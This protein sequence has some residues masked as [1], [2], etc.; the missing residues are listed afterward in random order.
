MPPWVRHHAIRDRRHER[1]FVLDLAAA[2]YFELGQESGRGNFI[3]VDFG[4]SAVTIYEGDD[5]DAYKEVA[6]YVEQLGQ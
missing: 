3:S 4:A 2:V 1:T 6:A 5:P